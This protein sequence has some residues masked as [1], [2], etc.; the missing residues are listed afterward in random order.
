LKS[1]T[2]NIIRSI[3]INFYELSYRYE[4]KIKKNS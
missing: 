4:T 1:P 3:N 2:K